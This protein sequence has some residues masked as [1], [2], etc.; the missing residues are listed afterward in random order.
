MSNPPNTWLS[1]SNFN[2]FKG[3]YFNNDVDC[4]GNIICR[5]GNLYLAS[6]SN[7]YSPTN[8]I[9]FDDTYQYVTERVNPK[10]TIAPQNPKTP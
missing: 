7:I 2:K 6:N 8:S 10:I 9:T 1:N 5:T 4:S 3:T